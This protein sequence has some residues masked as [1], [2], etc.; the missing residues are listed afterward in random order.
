MRRSGWW[1][2][3]RS[4]I[5]FFILGFAL[6]ALWYAGQFPG[7]W[8]WDTIK[9]LSQLHRKILLDRSSYIYP[10]FLELGSLITPDLS[11][12]ALF[13]ALLVSL[14]FG[15]LVYRT[16][17]TW[18]V[19]TPLFMKIAPLL[20]VTL[21][22]L[23]PINLIY[24]FYF[25]R[26]PFFSW[27]FLILLFWIFFLLLGPAREK[28]PALPK[29]AGVCLLSAVVTSLRQESLFLL[30]ALPVLIF[31]NT[32]WKR[33]EYLKGLSLFLF[34][35]VFVLLLIPKLL[36]VRSQT[37]PHSVVAVYNP[38]SYIIVHQP[39]IEFSSF[40]KTSLF[41][42]ISKEQIISNYTDGFLSTAAYDRGLIPEDLAPEKYEKFLLGSMLIFAKH[43][44]LFFEN[45]L[46]TFAGLVGASPYIY[47]YSDYL[48]QSDWTRN[49]ELHRFLE[50][51]PPLQRKPLSQSLFQV[52]EK[53]ISFA[54][55]SAEGQFFRQAFMTLFWPLLLC[56]FSV[57]MYSKAPLVASLSLLLLLRT[58][59]LFLIQPDA[60]FH[61]HY[62]LYLYGFVLL[63]LYQIE[64][65]S[66]KEVSPHG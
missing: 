15:F 13:M 39:D 10:Q 35:H 56:L 30:V 3:L 66:M 44:L 55:T 51:L 17:K 25:N 6:L 63:C 7:H 47:Y 62:S 32:Q 14:T 19:K 60:T 18:N 20:M 26:D 59:I 50:D 49:K 24:T 36:N 33:S 8:T 58:F 42:L 1:T 12:N 23:S 2:P 16:Q 4:G 34:C 38:L 52:Q 9:N 57:L 46:L 54:F 11:V 41:S 21:F 27:L 31:W 65:S 40:E 43:P 45:R 29:L 64:K 48:D 28:A 22:Y 5:L 37:A 61:Y 53:M